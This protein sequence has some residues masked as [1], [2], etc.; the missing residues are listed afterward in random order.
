MRIKKKNGR[1]KRKE[2]ILKSENGVP[3]VVCSQE[4]ESNANNQTC[5]WAT[6][7]KR[8]LMLEIAFT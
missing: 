7:W 4:C 5:G 6:E 2:N 3:G 8:R 1:G